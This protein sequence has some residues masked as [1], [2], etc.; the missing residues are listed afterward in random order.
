MNAVTCPYC[1]LEAS[2]TRPVTYD[3]ALAA[4]AAECPQRPYP[5]DDELEAV[6]S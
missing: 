5:D 6:R 1:G 2:Y 3:E 4:L